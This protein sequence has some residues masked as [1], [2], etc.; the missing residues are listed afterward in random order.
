MQRITISLEETLGD[1]LDQMASERGYA[2][3]SEAMRDLVRDGLERWRSEAQPAAYCV[4]NLSYIVDRRIRA[5][6]TRLADMQHAHHDLVAASTA[7]RLD[8]YHSLETLILRGSGA[9]VAAF[10]NQVRSERGIR[11]GAINMLQVSATDSHEGADEHVHH[12]HQ[13]LSPL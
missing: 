9:A 12:G 5:L 3:R 6:P 13:H 7:V 10:A 1:E 11:F 8:H 2:S 4:A